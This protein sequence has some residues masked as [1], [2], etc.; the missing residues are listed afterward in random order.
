MGRK[1]QSSCVIECT[2]TSKHQA[3]VVVDGN[4]ITGQNP[5]SAQGVGEAIDKA[6]SS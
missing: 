1:Y 3:H 5:A 2:L 4:L 6:L